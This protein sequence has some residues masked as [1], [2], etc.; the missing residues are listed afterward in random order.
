MAKLR[1]IGKVVPECIQITVRGHPTL[2]WRNAEQGIEAKFDV[3]IENNIVF[4][5][6]ESNRSDPEHLGQ[7][8]IRAIDVAEATACLVAFR[9]GLGVSIII[10]KVERE[11]GTLDDVVAEEKMLAGLAT[12]IRS[13]EG[14]EFLMNRMLV[15]HV[16]L[17]AL[18]DLADS[19]RHVHTA[20]INCT[21]A[22]DA[23]CTYFIPEGKRRNDGWEPMRL[24]L[25]V[26]KAYLQSVT[27]FSKG[28]RHGQRT[29]VPDAR[30]GEAGIKTWKV[31]DRFLI[32]LKRGNQPLSESEFPLLD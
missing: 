14:T 30:L 28:P 18:R 1:F 19:I 10:D 32:Y 17:L 15:D 27:E 31:M 3:H 6:F 4:V 23:I 5:D 9:E 29:I 26:S 2:N 13:S 20:A 22:L 21:R 25:N 24:A 12:S 7:A 16:L 11:D 8:V